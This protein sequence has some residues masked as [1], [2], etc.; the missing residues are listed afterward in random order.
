[1]ICKG[2]ANKSLQLFVTKFR[3]ITDKK[4]HQRLLFNFIKKMFTCFL[5]SSVSFKILL[6]PELA[7]LG[8]PKPHFWQ[9][10]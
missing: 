6:S 5:M 4:R 8:M 10:N 2:I 3:K 1:M 7:G 9:T